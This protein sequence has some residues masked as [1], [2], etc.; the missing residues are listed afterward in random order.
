MVVMLTEMGDVEKEQILF[1]LFIYFGTLPTD[2]LM[3]TWLHIA[4]EVNF[5]FVEFEMHKGCSN[6]DVQEAKNI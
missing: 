5:V 2:W 1:I 3:L 4:D 6:G